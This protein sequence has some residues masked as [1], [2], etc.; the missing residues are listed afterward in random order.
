MRVNRPKHRPAVRLIAAL[1][2]ALVVAGLSACSPITTLKPY[3]PS[4][5]VRVVLAPKISVENLMILSAAEG[6]P[7]AVQ[8]AI[9]NNSDADATVA[10]DDN[11]FQVAAGDTFL[12]GGTNG[13]E[14]VIDEVSVRPGATLNVVV[15]GQDLEAQDVPVPV[16]DGTIAPYDE[17]L[18]KEK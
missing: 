4:D 15:S 13:A 10:I 2:G 9:R 16:L 8:G 11:V 5:G 17:F 14:L 7:G 3:S 1:S 18:P 6:S 12:L